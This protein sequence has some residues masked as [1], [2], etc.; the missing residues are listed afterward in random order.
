MSFIENINQNYTFP[1]ILKD[2]SK[3]IKTEPNQKKDFKRDVFDYIKK[4]QHIYVVEAA[5]NNVNNLKFNVQSSNDNKSFRQKNI[6]EHLLSL[7]EKFV[8]AYACLLMFFLGAPLGAIV[9]K[10]GLGMPIVLAVSIFIIYHFINVFGK[11]LAGENTLSP[12]L[13]AWISSLFLTPFAISFTIKATKDKGTM[14]TGA[15]LKLLIEK[16]ILYFNKSKKSKDAI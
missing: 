2:T 10:G 4:E 9:R 5:F 6:N 12:F 1:I 8:I 14:D 11:K 3:T 15:K 16:I 7:N 13:G